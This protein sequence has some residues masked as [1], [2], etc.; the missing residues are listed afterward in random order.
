MDGCSNRL[1]PVFGERIIRIALSVEG[2]ERVAIVRIQRQPEPDTLWQVGIRQE[3]PPE[4][5]HGGVS[6]F[7]DFLSR[8]GFK[9]PGCDDFPFESLS[10]PCRRNHILTLCWQFR[11][12]GSQRSG[13][14]P[15]RASF[16]VRRPRT[17]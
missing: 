13:L 10:E 3:M 4:G 14:A 1:Q 6:V 11:R 17:S 12:V 16:Y 9:A 5:N 7:Y 15:P 8:S 2:V